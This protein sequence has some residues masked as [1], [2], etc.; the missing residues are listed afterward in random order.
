MM[1][2][3]EP[4]PP[5][6]FH[7][8][9]L[10]PSHICPLLS[11]VTDNKTLVL[12]PPLIDHVV[13]PDMRA[14]SSLTFGS[15]SSEVSVEDAATHQAHT[16]GLC[17]PPSLTL[18]LPPSP[19]RRVLPPTFCTHTPIWPTSPISTHRVDVVTCHLRHLTGLAAHTPFHKQYVL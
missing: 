10:Q 8:L 9:C 5:L 2:A 14:L 16:G 3:P 13:G 19:T 6:I 12:P 18:C 7:P 15:R 4:E 11:V 17:P 1:P